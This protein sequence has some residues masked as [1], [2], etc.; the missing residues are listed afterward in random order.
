MRD[1]SPYF[2]EK[3][4]SYTVNGIKYKTF[5]NNF[6]TDDDLYETI[7]DAQERSLNLGCSGYRAVRTDVTGKILYGPCSSSSTYSDIIKYLKPTEMD[8]R[9][10]EF[11][12]RDNLFDYKNSI[13]DD[14]IK[15]GFDYKNAIF[16]RSMSN[17]MFKDPQKSEILSYFQRVVFALIETV[18]QIRNSF[19]YTVPFNNRRVF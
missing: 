18:K 6:E 2:E 17:V 9:Y 16:Q 12:Q 5:T 11:D 14:N 7:E 1:Y 8:R 13:N 10:Y 4:L 3:K 15:E 19:N